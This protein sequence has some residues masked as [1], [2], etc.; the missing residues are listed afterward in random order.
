MH[1][2]LGVEQDR[3]AAPGSAVPP[4]EL[5]G[6]RPGGGT[7]SG[8]KQR[9]RRAGPPATR[10]GRSSLH[11]AAAIWHRGANWQQVGALVGSGRKPR[12]AGRSRVGAG[13]SR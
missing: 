5:S 4:A 9:D 8:K 11:R 6:P 12:I 10:S 1:E 3:P 13:R 7:A 2:V